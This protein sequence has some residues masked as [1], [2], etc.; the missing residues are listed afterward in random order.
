MATD[1]IA[2]AIRQKALTEQ[3]LAE[4]RREVERLEKESEEYEEFLR[5]A[6]KLTPSKEDS[7]ESR[8]AEKPIVKTESWP[9]YAAAFLLERG[10]SPMVAIIDYVLDSEF[11]LANGK[12]R[13]AVKNA[14]YNAMERR[15]DIFVISDGKYDL[16]TRDFELLT[17]QEEMLRSL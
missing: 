16:V 10:S 6:E 7:S 3:K 15:K 5:I 1:L 4:A 9:G 8:P 11:D 2:Q 13:K 12:S 14:L 17:D